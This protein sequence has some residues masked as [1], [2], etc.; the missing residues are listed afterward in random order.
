[1]N[2]SNSQASGAKVVAS[3]DASG[4]TSTGFNVQWSVNNVSLTLMY[5]IEYKEVQK[6]DLKLR[7]CAGTNS[8]IFWL[9]VQK[10]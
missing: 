3:V 2:P 5:L 7:L 4:A 8:V 6:I 1:L 10:L 9:R